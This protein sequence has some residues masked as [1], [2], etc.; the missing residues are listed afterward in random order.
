MAIASKNTPEIH[1]FSSE[2]TLKFNHEKIDTQRIIASKSTPKSMIKQQLT[3]A[4]IPPKFDHEKPLAASSCMDRE[5]YAI[6]QD[7]PARWSLI[8][9]AHVWSSIGFNLLVVLVW[10]RRDPNFYPKLLSKRAGRAGTRK[11]NN[12]AHTQGSRAYAIS[13]TPC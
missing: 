6:S 8:S 2:F 9:E 4:K 5:C 11:R 10:S 13:C 7:S 3:V 12:R 1:H